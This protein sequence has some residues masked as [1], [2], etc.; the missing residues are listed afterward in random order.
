MP[1]CG[2]RRWSSPRRCRHL[3]LAPFAASIVARRD[4]GNVLVTADLAGAA[5]LASIPLAWWFDM[6]SGWQVLAVAGAV[7]AVF[8]LRETAPAGACPVP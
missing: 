3:L 1:R 8:V 2:P 5:L 6:L 7:Q 4:V